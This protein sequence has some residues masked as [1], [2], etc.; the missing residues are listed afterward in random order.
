MTTFNDINGLTIVGFRF[1]EAPKSGRSWNYMNNTEECGVSMAQVGYDKEIG[2]FATSEASKRKRCY[3]IGEICGTGGDD[4]ICLKNVTKITYREYCQKRK[5]MAEQSNLVVNYRYDRKLNLIERGFNI[6]ST[7]DEI[8][9]E[10]NKYL[11]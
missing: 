1:G 11:R 4:E 5:E 8:E 7:V 2:S 10:R 3:Y 9:N 6:C